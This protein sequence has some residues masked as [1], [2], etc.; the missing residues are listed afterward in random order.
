MTATGLTLTGLAISLGVVYLNLR[1]WWKGGH[2]AKQLIPFGEGFLLGALST[3]CT[4]GV[5]GWLAGCSVQGANIGG[6]K[7]VSKV[8]GAGEG[9]ALTRGDLG[10]L[11][12]EGAIIVF[13]L[14][15]ACVLAWK[16]AGKK[17][18]RRMIGGG[19]CGA[20]LCVTAGVAG[21]LVWL[22]DVINMGGDQLR[23]AA[24]GAGIL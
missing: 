13:L 8:T 6:G 19:F 10:Q 15:V 9:A 4:G 11:T 23:A 20:T 2:E 1:P 24:E 7:V 12:P 21:A 22:P 3:I 16:T 14:F 5:L 18:K 17:D